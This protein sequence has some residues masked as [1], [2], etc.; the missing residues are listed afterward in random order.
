[1]MADSTPLHLLQIT[2]TH[3][4]ANP[5]GR[6]HGVNTR[7]TLQT[8]LAAARRRPPPDLVLLTGDL[9]H[10][11]SPAG[12]R[13]LAA[14]LPQLAVPVACVAGNHDAYPGFRILAD[15]GL[16]VGGTQA[17]GNWRIVL[18]NTQMPGSEGGHLQARELRLL[19][20]ALA[21]SPEPHI[22]VALHHHPLPMGSA[23]LDHIA[24]DNADDFFA[25]LDA[26]D[27]VRGVIWGHVHQLHESQR[28]GVRLLG[29]PSSCIQ[30]R[31]GS[32][33]FAPDS[34]PPAMRW[35]TLHG[36]GGID[37]RVEWVA[38]A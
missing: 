7:H 22:L 21:Q 14:M 12:Y 11:G 38:Q 18:L 8:V 6:L 35:L 24:L 32:R 1:M 16:R 3:L 28:R 10:D 5:E 29:T 13:A 27:K 20:E 19:S 33:D 25:A 30:F 15:S 4:F 9:V 36:D 2:D 26:S 23:W 34:R 17:L 37:T 31:P